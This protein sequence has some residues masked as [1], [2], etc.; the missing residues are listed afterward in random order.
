LRRYILVGNQTPPRLD[1]GSRAGATVS[2]SQAAPAGRYEASRL[3][4]SVR[5]TSMPAKRATS[6]VA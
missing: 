3:S 5:A 1:D 2:V 4:I 6:A